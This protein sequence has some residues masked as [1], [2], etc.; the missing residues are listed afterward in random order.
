MSMEKAGPGGAGINKISLLFLM[1]AVAMA[2]SVKP[3]LAHSFNAVLVLPLSGGAAEQGRQFR[4]GFM[5]ATAER[6]SHPDQESDGHL[7]G[8][9]VYVRVVD[10]DA[11]ALES[12]LAAQG[13]ADIAAVFGE[14]S[15]R[16]RVRSWLGGTQT[17]LLPPGQTPFA[18]PGLA[19]VARFTAAYRKAYDERPTP[20]A[21]QGYNAARRIAKAVRAQ[22]GI[23]D[24]A[25]LR[26][27][28]RE[29]ARGF[30]W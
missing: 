27:V 28:F 13:K 14:K 7:G 19:A 21:A 30:T 18:D 10:A 1:A 2:L 3:A 29:T 12:R 4:H 17:L 9:D 16:T 26:R 6:D 5:L 24:S 20:A 8:L 15:T 22:G 11:D 23:G 25:A